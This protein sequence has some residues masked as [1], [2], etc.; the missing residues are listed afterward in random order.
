MPLAYLR[1][2]LSRLRV[3]N[4]TLVRRRPVFKCFRGL[5]IRGNGLSPASNPGPGGAP[6]QPFATG[7][8]RNNVYQRE[9]PAA[10]AGKLLLVALILASDGAVAQ[11][12]DEVIDR[13]VAAI[14][15]RAAVDAIDNLVYANGTYAEGDFSSDGNATMS[16]ARPWF[17]L[18]GDKARPDSYMEGY[19][20]AAWEWYPDPGVVLRTTGAASAAIRHYAGVEHPLIDYRQ[21]GSVAEL[22]G[23]SE[24]D[25]RPVHVVRLSRRDGFTEQ[26]YLDR[27]TGL[28]IAS[29]AAAPIHAFGAEV[30]QVTRIADYRAVGG[31]Q[32]P[33][34][35]V[36][37]EVPS[38]RELSSMQ[39]DRI[40]ANR[41]LPD[42]WF[43]PP[44]VERTPLQQ[45]VENLF[46]QRSDV[47]ALLWT[48]HAFRDANP[49]VDTEIAVNFAGYQ[50]LKMGEVDTATTLLMENVAAY[51]Q[52][53]GAHFELGRAFDAAGDP[54]KARKAYE[55]ALRI[56]PEHERAQRAL[57]ALGN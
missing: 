34:R 18:V 14:G 28:I 2:L 32:V 37:T 56:D 12:V 31:M 43:A 46:G 44:D 1:I 51:P 7:A 39:W 8:H 9:N 45:L 29:G 11:S 48:Y 47:D 33:H 10:L 55:E 23:E 16:L 26:F 5:C 6:G 3:G 52:R 50:V 30:S 13:F 27:E 57:A 22:L 41:A 19:D 17:K 25:D 53:V 15:G 4:G 35:F 20:G 49:G 36:S 40:E 24:L 38:G 21:K 42:D 54:A